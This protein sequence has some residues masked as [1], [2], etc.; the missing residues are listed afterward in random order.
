MT[1]QKSVIMPQLC[2]WK[3]SAT[4]SLKVQLLLTDVMPSF[5]A[6]TLKQMSYN[7][8]GGPS[9]FQW[10]VLPGGKPTSRALSRALLVPS[11]ENE[12]LLRPG[13][14]TLTNGT[15]RLMGQAPQEHTAGI[16]LRRIPNI[17]LNDQIHTQ[18]KTK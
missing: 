13:D 18:V 3:D 5:L 16:L 10:P 2:L 6:S 12:A 9:I 1:L 17:L 14:T 15:S 4:G 11:N 7:V 8:N